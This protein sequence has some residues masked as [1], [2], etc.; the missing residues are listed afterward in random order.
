MQ[1][2]TRHSF[3]L[4]QVLLS[5]SPIK[6]Y[7]NTSKGPYHNKG[8][9]YISQFPQSSDLFSQIL[10]LSHLFFFFLYS[11]ISWYS[12]IN[13]YPQTLMPHSTLI[14]SF[15]LAPSGVCSYNFSLYSDLFFLQISQSTFFPTLPCCL[16]LSQCFTSACYLLHTFTFFPTQSTQG[17]FTGLIDVVLHIVC[18]DCLLL[19]GT[20]QC[21]CSNI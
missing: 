16:F 14:S 21:F 3:V 7:R 20:Q 10:G 9:L 18:P 15:S 17:V 11:Y 12:N 4:L 19:C 1:L 2:P 6:F 8:N 5:H 13:N